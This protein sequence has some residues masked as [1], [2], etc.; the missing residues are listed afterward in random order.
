MDWKNIAA[1]TLHMPVWTELFV[2]VFFMHTAN[3]TQIMS[4]EAAISGLRGPQNQLP[5]NVILTK[6]IWN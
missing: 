4:V 3:K 6:L 5:T 2:Q 1:A